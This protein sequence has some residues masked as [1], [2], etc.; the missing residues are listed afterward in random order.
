MEDLGP[1][2]GGREMGVFW[3]GEEISIGLEGCLSRAKS[4][5]T[6]ILSSGDIILC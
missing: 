5:A 1:W 2:R 6:N 4:N 3:G